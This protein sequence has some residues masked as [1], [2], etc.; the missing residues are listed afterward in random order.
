MQKKRTFKR[1]CTCQENLD[2]NNP[3]SDFYKQA[4]YHKPQVEPGSSRSK[5]KALVFIHEDEGFNWNNMFSQPD[6]QAMMAEIIEEPQETVD[7]EKCFGDRVSKNSNVS[8]ADQI[9]NNL[10]DVY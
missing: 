6:R 5:N 8:V 4:I 1:E 3:F 10:A 9:Y 2:N 7:E